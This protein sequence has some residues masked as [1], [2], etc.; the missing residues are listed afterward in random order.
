MGESFRLGGWGMYPTLVAGIIYVF[1]AIQYA[2]D[3]D[4]R[5]LGVVRSLGML[6]GVVGVLGFT[7]GIIHAF[8]SLG[9]VPEPGE[10]V[11]IALI[12]TGESACNLGLA[13]VMTVVATIATCVG[14]Y[15]SVKPATTLV[16]PHAP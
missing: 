11:Q 4:G 7:S 6:T 2:R 8:T 15:R 1:A 10:A 14:K 12:G 3:P 16:D 9:S 5:R 13:M